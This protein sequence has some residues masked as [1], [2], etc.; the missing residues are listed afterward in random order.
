M[1]KIYELVIKRAE[2][3]LASGEVNR[4]LGWKK[5]ELCYE[6]E[7][8][9]FRSVEEL[10]DFCYDDFAG[11]NL[12]KYL[13]EESKKEGKIAVFLKPCDAYSYNRLLKEHRVNG[14]NVLAVGVECDGKLDYRKIKDQ[15]V[16]GLL[17]AETVDE[18]T[19][20]VTSLY[21]DSELVRGEILLEKCLA[22]KTRDFVICD[23]KLITR[24]TPLPLPAYDRFS[25]VAKLEEMS[26]EERFAFWKGELSKCI[27]CNACRNVCPACTC[28]KCVFDNADS[29][30]AT[31]AGAD[32]FEEQMFHIIRAFH[33][34]GRCVDCGECSR[35]CPEHIPLHLLNR[36][37]IKDINTLYGEYESGKEL[38]A[39]DPLTFY[40]EGDKDP[41]KEG[42]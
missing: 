34:A 16:K 24:E 39:R 32:E 17:T 15:G 35:V 9:V 11:A 40:T 7:P 38:D 41:G 26:E 8:Y 25:E 18:D 12:A 30:M 42:K 3:L 19:V 13:V 10:K 27:R 36:K 33:V 28:V 21:G 37:F 23:E 14:D 1:S 22:C 6:V 29:G 2:E 5:G 31:K 4:V 20:K